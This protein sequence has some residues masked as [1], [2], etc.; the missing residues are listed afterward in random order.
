MIET[1]QKQIDRNLLRKSL[2]TNKVSLQFIRE[3]Q[4]DEESTVRV[5]KNSITSKS[6]PRCFS[7]NDRVILS[8]SPVEQNR[9]KTR[10][11]YM[12]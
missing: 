3:S 12:I 10:N 1:R 6:P 4:N 7:G 9:G 5:S 2:D 11:H 8:N